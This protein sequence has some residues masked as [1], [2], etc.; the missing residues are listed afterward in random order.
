M[1]ID[2]NTNTLHPY[3]KYGIQLKLLWMLLEMRHLM[4]SRVQNS[5]H[6]VTTIMMRIIARIFITEKSLHII[7]NIQSEKAE[8]KFI[9]T[10]S[11]AYGTN[12]LNHRFPVG[13][14]EI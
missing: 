9:K 11:I 13:H 14:V 5:R 1:Y 10:A 4:K 6:I 8:I 3:V 7:P 12:G 2:K